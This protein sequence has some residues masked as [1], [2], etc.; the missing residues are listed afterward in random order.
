M[1]YGFDGAFADHRGELLH[2]LLDQRVRMNRLFSG[3]LSLGATTLRGLRRRLL[4][5]L[6]H[7][8]ELQRTPVVLIQRI[9]QPALLRRVEQ[10]LWAGSR[11][12]SQRSPSTEINVQL[13]AML[14][15]RPDRPSLR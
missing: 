12:I 15:V 2:Q 9:V 8:I 13:A 3:A 1:F 6:Q 7:D 10:A 11:C 14:P 5:L 4:G